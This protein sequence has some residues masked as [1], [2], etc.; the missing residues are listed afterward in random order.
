[1]I[2]G[3]TPAHLGK[4]KEGDVLDTEIAP[5]AGLT[6]NATLEA[7]VKS[8]N[9]NGIVTFALRYFGV[10]VGEYGA[11]ADGGKIIWVDVAAAR[12]ERK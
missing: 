8:V 7:T 11:K 10:L 2:Q 1:M 9:K 5:L 3:I 6:E 12:R 4:L